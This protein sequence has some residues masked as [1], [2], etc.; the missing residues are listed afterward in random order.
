M[1]HENLVS[2]SLLLLPHYYLTATRTALWVPRAVLMGV[3]QMPVLAFNDT[4]NPHHQ[5]GQPH[6]QYIIMPLMERGALH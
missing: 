4:G 6:Y 1:R 2:T 3:V 5:A